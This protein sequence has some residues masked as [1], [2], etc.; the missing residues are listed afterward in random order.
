M[1]TVGKITSRKLV[2]SGTGANVMP[3]NVEVSPGL[4]HASNY[5]LG[6]RCFELARHDNSMCYEFKRVN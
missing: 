1:Y 4:M 5:T 2:R 6:T 3:S